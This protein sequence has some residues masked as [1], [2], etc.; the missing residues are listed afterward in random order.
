MKKRISGLVLLMLLLVVQT[1]FGQELT[2]SGIVTDDS[3]LPTPGVN[4]LIKGTTTGVATDFDGK[5]TIKASKGQVLSFSFLGMQTQDITVST[6]NI[7]VKLLSDAHELDDVVV[8]ALG[9]KRDKKQLGYATQEIKGDDLNKVNSGNIANSISGKASG[10]QIKRNNNIGGSTNV[11]VRGPSSLTGNNQALWVIDGMPLD[12]SNSNSTGQLAGSGGYDYG[13][14]ASDINPEDIESMNILKGSA[15][16]ALYGSRAANGAIIITT[17]KGKKG[18]GLGVTV[19]SGVSIGKIDRST[20]PKYQ[21]EYGSGYQPGFGSG[22]INGDGIPESPIVQTDSDASFGSPFDP[23][24]LV[25]QWDSFDPQSPNYMKKTPWTAAKNGPETFFQNNVILTN[26]VSIT[27]SSDNGTF[28]LSYSKFDQNGILPNSKLVR[29]NANFSGSHD[30]SDKLKATVNAN[31]VKTEGTGLNETGY[32]DNIITGFRQWWQNNVDLQDQKQAFENT[33]RNIS[34]NPNS[35]EDKKAAYWDNPYWQR[36]NNYNNFTRERFFGNI[37]LDY[38]VNDWMSATGRVSADTY[39]ELQ[40][41]RVAV[42]SVPVSKYTRF[43]KTFQELNYDMILNFKASISDRISF[44]GMLGSNIRRTTINSIFSSTNG[45]LL[46]PDVYTISNSLNPINAPTESRSTVGVDGAYG[47]ASFGFDDTVFVEGTLRRDHSSTLPKDNAVYYYPSVTTSYIFSN[48]INQDWLS[49]GKLRANYAEVGSD[50][51]F[52]VLRDLY[53]KPPSVGSEHSFSVPDAKRNP[54]LKNENTKSIEAGLE[55]QFFNKRLGFDVSV[56]KSNTFNLIM[57]IQVTAATGYSSIWVNAGEVQNTGVELMLNATPV[58]AKD[59]SWKFNVNW[60]KNKNEVQ[61]LYNGVDN[62]SLGT[63]QGG[64]SW[65]AEVGQ[66]MGIMKGTDYVY[67]NGERLVDENGYYVIS[68]SDQI[69]GNTQP[70]WVGGFTNTFTY[71]NLS[72]SFLIDVRKGGDVFSLDQYYGQGTGL[73]E[74]TVGDN[75]LGNPKRNPISEGGGIINP[76]VKPDGSPND[77]RIEYNS[78]TTGYNKLPNSE[79]VYDGSYVKLRELSLAYNIPSKM[80][81]KTFFKDVTFTLT[82][83]NLWIIHKNTPDSD[84]EAGLS[85]GN[86]QGFQSG[87]MPTTRDISFNIKLQF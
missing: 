22:D 6:S 7:N 52:A 87:V 9:I 24:M 63:F 76:G 20:F 56:Y 53:S 61:S 55:M 19:N 21:K 75:D 59:F 33:N 8:T 31:Y 1:G 16:T 3:G 37:G 41:E 57:P 44:A 36:H 47:S 77:K 84:P 74:N 69:I 67:V 66:P 35:A 10:V 62:L 80:L 23:N 49:F 30:L 18:K 72:L 65:N 54:N 14:T 4:I 46:V 27:G 38:K 68:D 73:Y 34:W 79:F 40:E 51:A 85:S 60:S 26:S 11:I 86:N 39:S 28:R 58:Q 32:S 43:D 78:G 12:N 82:G 45:G 81:E 5:Y 83:S 25:Y 71:K 2:I 48:N 17:K 70:D 13:N 15:A 64:V 42:G 50:A 29:D